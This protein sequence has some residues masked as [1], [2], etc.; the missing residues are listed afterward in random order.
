MKS[1]AEGDGIPGYGSGTVVPHSMGADVVTLMV[2]AR[3][4]TKLIAFVSV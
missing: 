1:A 4:V 3:P 2:G